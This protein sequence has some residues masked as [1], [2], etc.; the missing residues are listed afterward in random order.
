MSSGCPSTALRGQR[1]TF[2]AA[3]L[4]TTTRCSSSTVMIGSIADSTMS[5]TWASS[6]RTARYAVCRCL[7]C[8]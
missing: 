7:T 8:R 3:A 2:S 4:N 1:N 6:L 5:L